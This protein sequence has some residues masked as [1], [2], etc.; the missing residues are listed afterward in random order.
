MEKKN[1]KPYFAIGCI[2]VLA[3]AETETFQCAPFQCGRDCARRQL[4]HIEKGVA[5]C[6]GFLAGGLSITCML[7]LV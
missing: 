5:K 4:D 2:T 1:R 3:S 6:F 7:S